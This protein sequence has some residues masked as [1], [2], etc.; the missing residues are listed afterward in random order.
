MIIG[1]TFTFESSH[2]LPDHPK[3]GKIHGH[4]YRLT[5]EVDG[6]IGKDH[7]VMDLH[8]LSEIVR[9][10]IKDYDH[11]SLNEFFPNPTCEEMA[12]AIFDNLTTLL[13]VYKVPELV[14]VRTVQLQ[15]GEGGYAKIIRS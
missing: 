3:C 14:T 9:D 11:T 6:P 7:M 8:L 4:T 13:E 1:K 5:V 15:E 10:I 2:F 12:V